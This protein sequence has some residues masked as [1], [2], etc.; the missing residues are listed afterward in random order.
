MSL[1]ICNV[2]NF[3]LERVISRIARCDGDLEGIAND[4]ASLLSVSDSESTLTIINH[5]KDRMGS[6]ADIQ[7]IPEIYGW[8][9]GIINYER[10]DTPRI[11]AAKVVIAAADKIEL[12]PEI[13]ETEIFEEPKVAGHLQLVVSN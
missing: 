9:Y 5:I 11:A 6:D 13:P 3:N 10:G 7:Y 1:N 12:M 4:L 2:T 8:A